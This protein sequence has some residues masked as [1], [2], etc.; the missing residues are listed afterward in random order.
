ME[1]AESELMI[2][3]S[4]GAIGA[5]VTLPLS[6]AP[7]AAV[8]L[9]G[10]S[11]SHRRDGQLDGAEHRGSERDAI[12]RWAHR[13][14]AAGYASIRWDKPGHGASPWSGSPPRI[15]DYADALETAY[16][17]LAACPSVHGERV[18][19]AGESAGAYYACWLARRGVH[20]AGHLLLG[21][22]ASDYERLFEFNYV[23][24]VEYARRT[25]GHWDWVMRVAPRALA[26]GLH[27][28][29][30]FT[31]ARASEEWYELAVDGHAWKVYLP[32]LLEQLEHPP[33]SLFDHLRGP[34]LV[35]QGDRDMNV[36]PEDGARIAARLSALGRTRVTHVTVAGGDHN[37][38]AAPD[39]YETRL[40]ERIDLSCLARPYLD[41]AYEAAIRWLAE[42]TRSL[43]D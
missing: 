18:L 27:F 6:S 19:I 15:D 24:T 30:M 13:L 43:N 20:P 4:G 16:R 32:T 8:V 26:N 33:L 23:R 34:V 5:T 3:V 22:L 1:F 40:R 17:F 38:Q 35:L 7:V 29:E 28:Q 10:G 12:R 39:D 42:T 31:R 36:P 9:A 41:R 14:A 25:P 21:A 37:Y 11:L 2:P